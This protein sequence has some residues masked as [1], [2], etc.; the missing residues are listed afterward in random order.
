M[1]DIKLILYTQWGRGEILEK[2]HFSVG[3]LVSHHDFL[4][5]TNIAATITTMDLNT[6]TT[7][8]YCPNDFGSVAVLCAGS[9]RACVSGG[10]PR[11]ACTTVTT[12]GGDCRSTNGGI[13]L[14]STN[15]R[16]RNATCNSVSRNTSVVRLVGTTNCSITAPNGRRFSCNVTHTGRMVTRTSFPCLSDG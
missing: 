6:P 5:T 8:T 1:A 7:S 9:I 11:L 13:L 2:N 4:G 12:L 14:M 16:V 15:S 10:S 3:R